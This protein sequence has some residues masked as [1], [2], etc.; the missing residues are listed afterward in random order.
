[1][2]ALL[3]QSALRAFALGAAVRL[4]LKVLRIRNARAEMTAWRIVLF[5]SLGMPLLLQFVAPWARVTISMSTVPEVTAPGVTK[6]E[7][8]SSTRPTP[9][10]GPTVEPMAVPMSPLAGS[11]T[12]VS[13]PPPTTPR[14]NIDWQA[15]MAAV[16][17]A[18]AAVLLT[19]PLIGIALTVRRGQ[20]VRLARAGPRDAMCA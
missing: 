10:P 2:I 8:E 13:K 20:H 19:R 6:I 7:A 14:H 4:G 16:Y 5:V 18:V 15:F 12:V 1:M 9:S 17:L 11:D 3:L